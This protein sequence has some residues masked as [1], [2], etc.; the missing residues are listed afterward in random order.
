MDIIKDLGELAIASRLRRISNSFM[1]E[2]QAIYNFH[3][4]EF[5]PRW[6]P[7]FFY[8][9]SIYPKAAGVTDIASVTRVS[10]PLINRFVKQLMKRDYIEEVPDEKDKRKRLIKLTH[11]GYELAQE[12]RAIWDEI[13]L[14][15][16][17]V[18]CSAEPRF[19][20][21]LEELEERIDR[22]G[23]LDTYMSRMKS[24]RYESVRIHLNNPEH[25]AAFKEINIQWLEKYFVV[26]PKDVEILSTP[27][28]IIDGGGAVFSATVNDEPLGVCALINLGDGALELSKMGVYE[29]ARGMQ[30]GKKLLDA[31][32]DYARKQDIRVIFLESSNQLKP[33][34][35]LYL[36]SGFEFTP[37]S[38]T[39][40]SV[41]K[42]A[43]VFMK[44]EL[45]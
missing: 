36:Q 27:K 40:V 22:K 24:R 16:R 29:K 31:A 12:L 25:Y 21:L 15:V 8:L 9:N 14:S 45:K 43:D 41:Y 18:V 3:Q 39:G 42:R 10:H 44:M 4:M 26:E 2:T 35:N 32:I 19:M 5:E 6:F 20:Q 11:S 33:A 7:T 38:H 34:L 17:E 23:L 37:S 1:N 28:K 13:E 30:I